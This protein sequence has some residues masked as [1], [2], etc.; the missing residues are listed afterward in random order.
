M[1]SGLAQIG[2]LAL[3]LLAS[4]WMLLWALAAVVPILIHLWSRRRY[5]EMPWAAMRFLLAAMRKNARRWR[6][7]QL[8]LLA[9]RMSILILLA[10][11]LADPML[12]RFGETVGDRGSSGETHNVLV[13]DASYSMDYRDDETTRFEWAKALATEFVRERL[14]GDGFTL[15][16]LADP[17]TVVVGDP[18]FD[19]ESMVTEL[20]Q[21]ERTDGGADLPAT[22]AEVERVVDTVAAR[23][24][25]LRRQRVCF[26]TDLGR[27][28]WGDAL[29]ESARPTLQRLAD[30]AVLRVYDVGRDADQNVAVTRLAVS[31]AV[32]TV[33]VPV[34]VEL[35]LENF[36]S[37]DRSQQL[38][39][40][41]ADGQQFAERTVD[42]DAGGRAS[43]AATHR[44]QSPGEHVLEARLSEDRLVADNH[45]WHCLRVGEAVKVLCVE[46]KSGAARHVALALEPE[47]SSVAAVRPVVRSE[48][49]LMEE[50]LRRY[51]AVILC[52]VG[53]FGDDEAELLR[54][55]LTRGGGVVLVLGDQVQADNYNAILGPEASSNRCF[56]F[57]LQEPVELGEYAFD[58]LGYQH[59][60]V[61]PFRGHERA[62]LLTTPVWK[63]MLVTI[64]PASAVTE[65]V[66]FEN[67][68]PAIL[69]ENVGNG[70]VVVLTTDASTVSMDRSTEPP[71]PWSALA[72]WPS[73]P[74]LMRQMLR[75]AVRG[76]DQLRNLTVGEAMRGWLPPGSASTSVVVT[77]PRAGS[78]RVPVELDGGLIQWTYSETNVGGLYSVADGPSAEHPQCFAVNLDTSESRLET[79]DAKQLSSFF[80]HASS[81]E[82]A[83]SPTMEL[84]K[85]VPLFRHLLAGVL[86]LLLGETTLAWLFSR[87]TR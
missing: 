86:V 51:D 54:Q 12:A 5:E 78:Q 64:D 28:S 58:P 62:G 10:I 6:L 23:Q 19:R 3:W 67:G 2:L 50:D 32:A 7:E 73:F 15:I 66:A 26:F 68:T 42:I 57:R 18:V 80:Q 69:E 20:S 45:R 33:S 17:P 71:T 55:F 37:Q 77:D 75:V 52:N 79:I 56:S 70:R 22:L 31:E 1:V 65:A 81:D 49:A 11:A 13:V 36:G 25:R 83:E 59:E 40:L 72:V 47:V 30:K 16:L 34:E 27:N 82:S 29:G 48:V 76:G 9:V 74:P 41:L 8:L 44:F 63:Y 35:E 87:A 4:P 53:R 21:L 85:P 61:A 38:V 14:Q 60:I 43:V 39:Q 24:S 46:G 84:A